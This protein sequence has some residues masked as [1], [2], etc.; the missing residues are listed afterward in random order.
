[1][2]ALPGPAC[3]GTETGHQGEELDVLRRASENMERMEPSIRKCSRTLSV[4]QIGELCLA[5]DE[6]G[7]L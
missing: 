4:S 1:M 3:V 6:K 5:L 2:P 7:E